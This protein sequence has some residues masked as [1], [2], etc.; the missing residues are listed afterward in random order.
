MQSSRKRG[1]EEEGRREIGRF[2]R[3]KSGAIQ[4][5]QDK[6]SGKGGNREKTPRAEER[7]VA[8]AE[9]KKAPAKEP[10]ETR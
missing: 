7:D 3:N 9:K 8:S 5:A 6:A 10:E 4:A 1:K 2:D